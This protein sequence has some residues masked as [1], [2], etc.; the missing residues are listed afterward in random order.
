MFQNSLV[1][2]WTTSESLHGEEFCFPGYNYFHLWIM[3]SLD[4]AYCD[5]VKAE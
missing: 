1:V 5:F 2:K 4:E 3:M